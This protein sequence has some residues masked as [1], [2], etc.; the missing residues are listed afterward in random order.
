MIQLS[1]QFV[2]HL[3]TKLLKRFVY[4]KL[5][6]IRN[7][8]TL[9]HFLLDRNFNCFMFSKFYCFTTTTNQLDE[10]K[11]SNSVETGIYGIFHTK[12]DKFIQQDPVPSKATNSNSNSK[13]NDEGSNVWKIL[14]FGLLALILIIIVIVV[15]CR[16]KGNFASYNVA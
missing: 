16:W 13:K 4:L 10:C 7:F 11:T 8:S 15:I 5:L 1:T 3:K 12:W 9:P 6:K 14:G 2:N